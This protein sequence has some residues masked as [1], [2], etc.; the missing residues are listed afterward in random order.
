M[1]FPP[2]EPCARARSLRKRPHVRWEKWVISAREKRNA[3]VSI[4]GCGRVRHIGVTMDRRS[5]RGLDTR[6][7]QYSLWACAERKRKK[8]GKYMRYTAEK[9]AKSN[10]KFMER[11]QQK[12][13]MKKM[14]NGTQCGEMWDTHAHCDLSCSAVDLPVEHKSTFHSIILL[15]A[16]CFCFSFSVRFH[17]HAFWKEDTR[18]VGQDDV[19]CCSLLHIDRAQKKKNPTQTKPKNYMANVGLCFF[20]IRAHITY[21]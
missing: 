7:H 16:C 18:K 5:P 11:E 13:K 12:V 1:A 21:K 14:R 9:K 20:P 10:S 17:A 19:M 4:Y 3:R 2:S 6:H 15:F 8:L